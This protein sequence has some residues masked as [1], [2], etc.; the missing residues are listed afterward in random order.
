MAAV[1]ERFTG[2][3]AAALRDA[4]ADASGNEVFALVKNMSQDGSHYWVVAHVTPTFDR[5]GRIIGYHSNRRRPEASAVRAIEPLY[6]R[7]RDVER[8]HQRPAAAAEA[9]LAMMVDELTTAGQDYD[10]FIWGLIGS[11]AGASA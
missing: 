3:A 1:E 9:S 7:M 2:A 11:R 8:G 5:T 10:H 6:A 4:I